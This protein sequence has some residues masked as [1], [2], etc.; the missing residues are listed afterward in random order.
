MLLAQTCSLIFTQMQIP[1]QAESSHD[2][3]ARDA[4]SIAQS[5]AAMWELGLRAGRPT[6]RVFNTVAKPSACST[7]AVQTIT[8][9]LHLKISRVRTVTLDLPSGYPPHMPQLKS[10]LSTVESSAAVQTVGRSWGMCGKNM[11][12]QACLQIGKVVVFCQSVCQHCARLKSVC[13]CQIPG[14]PCGKACR[15]PV[16]CVPQFFGKPMFI[17]PTKLVCPIFLS[18]LASATSTTALWQN[19]A[20]FWIWQE[21]VSSSS[22]CVLCLLGFQMMHQ[23]M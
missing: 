7:Q 13:N 3:A 12:Y 2:Q 10:A 17:E 6:W 5:V 16:Q 9:H 18:V 1:L 8:S 15:H 21:A 20:R 11:Q 22:G 19:I 4:S 23:D 14:W